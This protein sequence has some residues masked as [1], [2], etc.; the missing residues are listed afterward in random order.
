MYLETEVQSVECTLRHLTGR[1]ETQFLDCY[2]CGR[3]HP[4][5]AKK[6][7]PCHNKDLYNNYCTADSRV[8]DYFR[9]LSDAGLWPTVVPFQEYSVSNLA[10]RISRVKLYTYH[11]CGVGMCPLRQQ[12]TNLMQRV[13]DKVSGII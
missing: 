1:Y 8:A 6:C 7:H 9:I 10:L 3:S 12:L 13:R 2:L 4:A 5:N 11:R